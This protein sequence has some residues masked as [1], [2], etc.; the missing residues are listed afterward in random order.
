DRPEEID[1]PSP[2]SWAVINGHL[3]MAATSV[4]EVVM[5]LGHR[6][7]ERRPRVGDSFCG[8]GSL[9]FE[10][11]RLGCEAYGSDLSPVATLLT[12]AALHIVGGGPEIAEQVRQTQQTVYRHYRE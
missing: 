10:A 2:A 4:S 1:G 12:W 3:K 5:E 8:G 11:A 6:R 7:F 9:P